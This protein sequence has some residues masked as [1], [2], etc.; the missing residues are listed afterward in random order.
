MRISQ[1]TLLLC[2]LMGCPLCAQAQYPYRLRWSTD[3][4]LVS[5]GLATSISGYG[6]GRHVK[7]LSLPQITGLNAQ[8][9]PWIDRK[10]NAGISRKADRASDVAFYSA[11]LLPLVLLAERST[12]KEAGVVSLM[13]VETLAINAGLTEWTKNLA[14]RPRPYTYHPDFPLE[15]KQRRDARKSFFSGHT[16]STAASCFFVAKVW[17]DSHPK[18]RWKPAVWALAAGIPACT[19]YLRMRAGQHFF[20]DVSVGYAVGATLGY[21]IPVWHKSGKAP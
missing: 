21:L 7:P 16:S 15:R 12:R 5:A 1:Y 8:T 11:T 9:L 18:S 20:T 13:Y 2:F 4:P 6:F 3:L 14:K 17:S 10:T 19:G